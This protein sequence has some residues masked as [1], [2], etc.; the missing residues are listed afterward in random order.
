MPYFPSDNLPSG[1]ETLLASKERSSGR[2]DIMEQLFETEERPCRGKEIMDELFKE[3]KVLNT[4]I[5]F[6]IFHS[7][8]LLLYTETLLFLWMN[9]YFWWTHWYISSDCC[10]RGEGK[11]RKV[12]LWISY[13][14][15]LILHV[16]LI[17]KTSNVSKIGLPN[18]TSKIWHILADILCIYFKIDFCVETVSPR[19]WIW[20]P[21]TLW[22]KRFFFH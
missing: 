4:K 13:L 10:I 18:Q 19:Q 8:C 7:L 21:W 9:K 3:T 5:Y 12:R 14:V 15:I 1:K 20:I 22:S 16:P 2:K 6:F 11:N 17:L